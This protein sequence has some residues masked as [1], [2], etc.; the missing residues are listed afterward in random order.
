MA[1]LP[2]PPARSRAVRRAGRRGVP[3]RGVC[4]RPAT[5]TASARRPRPARQRT[6]SWPENGAANWLSPA[7]RSAVCSK[8]ALRSPRVQFTRSDRS[9]R[10]CVSG[11]AEQQSGPQLRIADVGIEQHRAEPAVTVNDPVDGVALRLEHVV[12]A[13]FDQRG[14]GACRTCRRPGR[15]CR[16]TLGA[17]RTPARGGDAARPSRAPGRPTRS[18]RCGTGSAGVVAAP[19]PGNLAPVDLEEAGIANQTGAGDVGV[20]DRHDSVRHKRP[21]WPNSSAAWNMTRSVFRICPIKHPKTNSMD[22]P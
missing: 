14:R 20:R 1:R 17:G 18:A 11:T 13:V 10:N 2:A 9:S 8:R 7:C 3:R 19:P 12:E 22:R 5:P 21:F 6:S 16:A 15:A 4:G